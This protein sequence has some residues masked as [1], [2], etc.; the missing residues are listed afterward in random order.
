MPKYIKVNLRMRDASSMERVRTKDGT[1]YGI[2]D[3]RKVAFRPYQLKQRRQQQWQ[4][5][6][7]HR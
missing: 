5:A 3:T 6:Q 1:S 4:R 2:N 7:A